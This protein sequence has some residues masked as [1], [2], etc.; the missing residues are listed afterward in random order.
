MSSSVVLVQV[1][2]LVMV[3]VVHLNYAQGHGNLERVTKADVAVETCL[4]KHT[5]SL[6]KM[7]LTWPLQLELPTL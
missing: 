6:D 5:W 3:L 7:A 4:S 1:C 2:M